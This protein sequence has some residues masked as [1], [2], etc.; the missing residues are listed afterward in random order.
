M[1]KL[2]HQVRG[3]QLNRGVHMLC[4]PM[5]RK[6]K[7]PPSIIISIMTEI[8][9]QKCTLPDRKSS[10]LS[11]MISD[12]DGGGSSSDRGRM[13]VVGI[14][15][16]AVEESMSIIFVAC[17]TTTS[18]LVLSISLGSENIHSLNI[19]KVKI[20]SNSEQYQW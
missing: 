2:Y 20:S 11:R 1:E 13:V 19:S 4:A 17:I 14:E 3:L 12:R 5:A 8:P 10:H 7:N 15:S 18:S 6:K 9:I 16:G